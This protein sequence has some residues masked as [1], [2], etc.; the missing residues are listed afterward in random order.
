MG[1]TDTKNGAVVAVNPPSLAAPAG[2]FGRAVRIG[3]FL[4]VSGTSALPNLAGTV[5]ERILPEGFREQAVTTFGN[6]EKVLVSQRA[7]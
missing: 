5:E 1:K 4:H 7:S 2:H 6:I 3:D